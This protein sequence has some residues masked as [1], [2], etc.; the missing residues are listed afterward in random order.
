MMKVLYYPLI[1]QHLIH[2]AQAGD[3]LTDTLFHGLRSILGEDLIDG[4]QMWHQ[5]DTACKKT[6]PKLWG[7]GFTTY[8]LLPDIEI[9]REDI[10]S[11]IQNKY[12]DYIICPMHHTM[13]QD[14][15][16]TRV[17]IEK[18]LEHYPA[19]KVCL[20][21]GWDR[22][23]TDTSL[24][25]LV[26]FFKREIN[27]KTKEAKP[28]SFSIPKEKIRPLRSDAKEFDF[29]PLVPAYGHFDDPHMESYI[30]NTEEEYYDMYTDSHFAY[31]CKKGREDVLE[32]SWD[33]MRHYEILAAGS[34]PYFTDIEKC[35]E[36]SMFRFPK[37][38][39]VRAKK[40]AGVFPGTKESF[41]SSKDTFIGTSKAIKSGED[42]GYIDFKKFNSSEY[43]NLLIEFREYTEKYLTTEAMAKYLLEEMKKCSE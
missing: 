1:Q 2:S 22:P 30:Y 40:M 20:V 4:Y 36:K 15:A 37:D 10:G 9:D 38:L 28:I 16:A 12:F 33:C 26:P 19:N 42:R 32:E 8:G 27:E 6:L 17:I 24:I 11:K 41:D 34:I 29:A 3:Y 25:S 39:C 5:Y 13:V 14:W 23:H 35:P 7:K 31:T 18:I 43:Q 21:D